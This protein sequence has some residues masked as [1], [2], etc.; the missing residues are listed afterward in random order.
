[1]LGGSL[2]VGDGLLKIVERATTTRTRDVFGLGAAQSCSLKNSESCIFD[3]GSRDVAIVHEPYAIGESVHHQ[4][5]HIS[6]CIELEVL[7]V[8]ESIHLG[9][10]HRIEYSCLHHLVD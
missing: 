2:D 1:M 3:V 5:S 6:S 7:L 10:H 8:V 4:R 9:K